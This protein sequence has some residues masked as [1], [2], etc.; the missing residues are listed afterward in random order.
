MSSKIPLINRE[1]RMAQ[2]SRCVSIMKITHILTI[3]FGATVTISGFAQTQSQTPAQTP[4][5]TQNLAVTDEELLKYATAVD[6]VNEMSAEAKLELSEMVKNSTVMNAARY[7][8]LNK[9]INDEA[10]LAEAK[11]T[12]EEI[13]F[14]KSVV[15]RREEEMASINSTYQSLA[16][17]YVTPAVFNK[18]KKA[19]TSD[20]D[21]KKRYDSLMV[22][23]AKDDPTGDEKG[24]Q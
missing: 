24:G 2:L 21:L 15:A 3:A 14:V 17:E 22:E 8:D 13:A 4:K 23:M 10:K 19:L 1:L 16:K 7:N 11:A 12:P 6:S 20:T 5:Q 18:V 9:I